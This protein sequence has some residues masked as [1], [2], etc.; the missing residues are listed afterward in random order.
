MA[1]GVVP[2]CL[3]VRSGIHEVVQSGV[4]GF[5]VN[6]REEDFQAAVSRLVA[7]PRTWQACSEQARR[8]IEHE[9]SMEACHRKWVSAIEETAGQPAAALRSYPI[10]LPTKVPSPHPN[11]HWRDDPFDRLLPFAVPLRN[12]IG[13]WR[14]RRRQQR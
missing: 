7:E 5:L 10:P 14:R 8:T 9:F 2:I 12:A 6:D 11:F 1:T 4:N 3:K 13:R